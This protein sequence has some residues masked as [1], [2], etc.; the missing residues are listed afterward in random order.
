[1]KRWIMAAVML[2]TAV[3]CGSKKKDENKAPAPGTAVAGKVDDAKTTAPPRTDVTSSLWAFAPEGAVLGIVLG[4]GVGGKARLTA[5]ALIEDLAARPVGAH[6]TAALA[7][8]RKD[9]G[10]DPL[11]EAGWKTMGID[12]SKGFAVFLNP[13]KDKEADQQPIMILPVVDRAAFLVKTKGKKETVDGKEVDRIEDDLV[14]A[15]ASDR[16]ICAKKPA[17]IDAVAKAHDSKLA[18]AVKALPPEARGDL[19]LYALVSA[20][21]DAA[22]ELEEMKQQ[23]GK[24]ETAGLSLRLESDGFTLHGWARGAFD[25]PVGTAMRSIAPRADFVS[26]TGNAA[27]V[28]RYTISPQLMFKDAPASIPLGGVDV[29]K[30]LLDQLT[31]EMQF[32]SAGRG[33]VAGHILL[34]I[35][36]AAKVTEAV[37]SLCAVGKTSI[38]QAKDNPISKLDLGDKGCKGELSFGMFEKQAG[39][40]LPVLPFSLAVEDKLLAL[41]FGDVDPARMAGNAADDAGSPETRAM[42]SG[43]ASMVSWSRAI[44]IDVDALPGTFVAE[45][46]KQEPMLLALDVLDWLGSNVYEMGF[47]ATIAPDV[48]SMTMRVTTFTGDPAEARAGYVAALQKRKAGDRPGYS[49]A[50]T[51]LAGKYPGTRVGKRAKLES[52]GSPVMGPGT[53]IAAAGFAAYF[54]ARQVKS[55]FEGVPAV[56]PP[57]PPEAKPVKPGFGGKKDAPAEELK[58]PPAE[59]LKAPPPATP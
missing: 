17:D 33:L 51:E 57:P 28:A 37:K 24:V 11:D 18:A 21:P 14:C 50:L 32:V 59:E 3:A 46:K 7:E 55:A 41:S 6:V 35:E 13:G 31:G 20:I 29:R 34:G 52:E 22:D 44:D 9:A 5:K 16:Y 30:N 2:S 10:F 19:E 45:L 8:V 54:V 40:T 36:D 27:T 4:D 26:K 47:A 15:P 38:G 49:A 58:K 48:A 53:A 1:M 25:G 43:P 56:E 39:V 12:P 23:V 42:L